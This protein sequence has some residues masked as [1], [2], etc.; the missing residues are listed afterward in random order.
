MKERTFKV[1]ARNNPVGELRYVEHEID[2][3]DFYYEDYNDP[4]TKE[5]KAE[6]TAWDLDSALKTL[7]E[8]YEE[9]L[10]CKYD[11]VTF[12]ELI[13]GRFVKFEF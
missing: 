5:V 7:I 6:L 8:H 10:N 2:D 11:D 3:R 4:R 12:S 13:N 1:Y 9:T